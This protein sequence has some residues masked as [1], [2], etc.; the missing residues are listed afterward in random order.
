MT[1]DIINFQKIKFMNSDCFF[2]NKRL[3]VEEIP[4]GYYAY[5]L[6]HADDWGIPETIEV[7]VGSNFYGT[8]LSRTRIDL[9]LSNYLEITKEDKEAF[10]LL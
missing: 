10:M 5:Q 3:R 1:V 2:S 9:G 7:F 8:L 4:E 6:R